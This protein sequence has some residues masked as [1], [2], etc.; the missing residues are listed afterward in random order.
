MRVK[1]SVCEVFVS[2]ITSNCIED[3]IVSNVL[4]VWHR[5][6]ENREAVI[7]KSLTDEPIKKN[8]WTGDK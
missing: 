3:I 8:H 6:K 1:W 7:T 4:R 5:L 2:V